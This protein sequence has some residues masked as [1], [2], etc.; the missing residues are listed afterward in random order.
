MIEEGPLRSS[1]DFHMLEREAYP[2][3]YQESAG[4]RTKDKGI[5]ILARPRGR[6]IDDGKLD[7]QL[8]HARANARVLA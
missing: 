2:Q 5:V 3:L 6:R 8:S 4:R 7:E 1:R